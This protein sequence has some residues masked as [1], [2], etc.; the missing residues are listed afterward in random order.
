MQNFVEGAGNAGVLL[1]SLG[2]FA[3]FGENKLSSFAD[4]ILRP[5]NL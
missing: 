5:F 1:I 3:Q 4:H 2:T